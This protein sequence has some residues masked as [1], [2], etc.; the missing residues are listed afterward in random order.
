MD[1]SIDQAWQQSVTRAVYLG[2]ASHAHRHGRHL[3]DPSAANHYGRRGQNTIAVENT[4]VANRERVGGFLGGER[5]V[6]RQQDQR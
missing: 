4:N 2:D 6:K 5:S 1:V 3:S